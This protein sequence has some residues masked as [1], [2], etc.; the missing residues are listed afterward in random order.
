MARE[1][2]LLAIVKSIWRLDNQKADMLPPPLPP[3]R[4]VAARALKFLV[5]SS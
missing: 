2:R 5:G 4:R 1:Q 3:K